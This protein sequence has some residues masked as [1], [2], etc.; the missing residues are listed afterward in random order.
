MIFT[1]T[2]WKRKLY[3]EKGKGK[4]KEALTI[5]LV[6]FSALIYKNRSWDDL[7]RKK[8]IQ[9]RKDKKVADKNNSLVLCTKEGG[10]RALKVMNQKTESE[11]EH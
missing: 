11:R 3:E 2:P 10:G 4:G 8:T 1:L 5:A 7:S 6:I 9:K